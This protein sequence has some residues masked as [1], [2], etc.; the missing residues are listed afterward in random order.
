MQGILTEGPGLR[1][2]YG[3][4]KSTADFCILRIRSTCDV[5]VEMN[6][7]PKNPSWKDAFWTMAETSLQEAEDLMLSLPYT[8]I[9]QHIYRLVP[10][11][12]AVRAADLVSSNPGDSSSVLV[13]IDLKNTIAR[14]HHKYASANGG[15]PNRD[16]AVVPPP[17]GGSHAG[18]SSQSRLE[19]IKNELQATPLQVP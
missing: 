18:S 8:Q 19:A 5:L 14:E 10:A 7:G 2:F 11:L 13:D 12:E 4:A 6:G 9:R 3:S 16:A 17:Y 1:S 15:F